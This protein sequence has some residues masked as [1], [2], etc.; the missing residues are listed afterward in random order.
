MKFGIMLCSSMLLLSMACGKKVKQGSITPHLKRLN[1]GAALD[2]ATQQ[3]INETLLSAN[4]SDLKNSWTSKL[5]IE[6]LQIPIAF[7]SVDGARNCNGDKSCESDTGFKKIY[8][9]PSSNVEDC[10]VELNSTALQDLTA[11]SATKVYPGTYNKVQIE[12]CLTTNGTTSGYTGRIKASVVLNGITYY[13]D[14]D[15]I[16]STTAPAKTIAI[17]FVGCGNGYVLDEPATVKEGEGID[18]QLYFELEHVARV[19]L[20]SVVDNFSSSADSS[21][22]ELGSCIYKDSYGSFCL[23]YLDIV[24]TIDNAA[25]K[26]ERYLLN[27]S[28]FLSIVFNSK[29]SP[30]GGFQRV[31]YAA[32]E[33]PERTCNADGP[34]SFS[35]NADGSLKVLFGVDWA[36]SVSAEN[37]NG[38]TFIDSFSRQD[39]SGTYTC[40]KSTNVTYTAKAL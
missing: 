30:V 1:T 35:T 19:V 37:G 20:G 24:G 39:H 15:T 14:P 36:K 17:D 32:G 21:H 10:Y 4:A 18:I 40:T 6:S 26:I 5:T 34:L 8:S 16:L 27:N 13:T 29:G 38:F 7:I 2:L 12:K 23:S 33:D 25:P 31:Y 9:C 11:A 3:Q 28:L 22:W